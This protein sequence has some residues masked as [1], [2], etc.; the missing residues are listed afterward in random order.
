MCML[1]QLISALC[2]ASS[3]SLSSLYL[4]MRKAVPSRRRS[5]QIPQPHSSSMNGELPAPSPQLVPT[6]RYADRSLLG[7]GEGREYD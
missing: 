5:P 6:S 2:F 7:E 3:F 1:R 4:Q